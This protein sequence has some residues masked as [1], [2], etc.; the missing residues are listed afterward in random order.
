M[1]MRPGFAEDWPK[2][3]KLDALLRKFD[4]GDYASVASGAKALREHADPA[5]RAAATELASRTRPDPALKW[6][7]VGML[8]VIVS[9]GGYWIAETH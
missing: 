2:N 3:A 8:I 9:V 1:G 5:V 7:F 6:L 4:E